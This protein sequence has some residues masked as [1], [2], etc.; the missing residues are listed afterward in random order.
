MKYFVLCVNRKVFVPHGL[1]GVV[2]AMLLLRE[3]KD[4][5]MG[6]QASL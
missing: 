2:S 4:D 6:L 1:D 5:E 3:R